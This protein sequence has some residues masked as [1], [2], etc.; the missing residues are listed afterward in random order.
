MT[1][2]LS[3]LGWFG[4]VGVTSAA[5]YSAGVFL[6]IGLLGLPPQVA[7]LLGLVMAATCSY[8]G[9][10]HLTFRADGDHRRY[11]PKFTAQVLLTY[12]LSTATTAIVSALGWHHG[13]TVAVVVVVIPVLNFF[14]LQF[15]VFATR[16]RSLQE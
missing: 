13:I 5:L 10:H 7:N 16:R 11:L 4:G 1:P 14:I 3:R 6:G 12:A 8:L 15:W 9:H 2:L